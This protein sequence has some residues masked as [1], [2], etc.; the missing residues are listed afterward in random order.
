RAFDRGFTLVA[1]LYSG[2][3]TVRREGGYRIAGV[4]EAAWMLDGMSVELI[5]DGAHLPPALLALAHRIKTSDRA[6]LVTDAMRA[7]GLPEGRYPLG[8]K[9]SGLEA[10][11]RDGVAWMPDGQAFAGS[12]A[13]A[14]RLLVTAVRDALIPLSDAVA[15]WSATPAR[16]AGVDNRKGSLAVGK[17]ADIAILGPDFAVKS[18][19]TRGRVARGRVALGDGSPGA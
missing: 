19:L 17:D 5:A 18:V 1:H 9:D 11:V 7:A 15:M 4:I 12:V 8:A 14:G 13:T 10:I 3:S 16:I 2:M 6:I